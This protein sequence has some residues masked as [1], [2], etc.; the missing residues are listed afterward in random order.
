MEF[1]KKLQ[2]RHVER[3]EEMEDY[4]E[5]MREEE[6]EDQVE[7]VVSKTEDLRDIMTTSWNDLEK[8][9]RLPVPTIFTTAGVMTNHF[10]KML[11][12]KEREDVKSVLKARSRW[13]MLDG[14]LVDSNP[15]YH[16]RG[17]WIMTDSQAFELYA[18]QIF[19]KNGDAGV[20][21]LLC[22][23]NG[24]YVASVVV[25]GS[26][27]LKEG[28]Y[29][30]VING[31]TIIMSDIMF[32]MTTRYEVNGWFTWD[33]VTS[34]YSIEAGPV[35]RNHVERATIVPAFYGMFA[36]EP[37]TKRAVLAVVLEGLEVARFTGPITEIVPKMRYLGGYCSVFSHDPQRD[38]A[39]IFRHEMKS[40][41]ESATPQVHIE[42]AGFFELG[43]T[44]SKFTL[45]DRKSVV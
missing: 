2:H 34:K 15:T 11:L 1:L 12:T 4:E 43:V 24:V 42:G 14:R 37:K 45:R 27:P 13:T 6:P 25:R 29:D 32:H 21:Q 22:Y 35:L 9:M 41:D 33:I 36:S 3:T 5:I 23:V 39:T 31:R 16:V 26:V 44:W 40:T 8:A 30:V 10:G 28:W 20:H 38:I 19:L 17:E 18:E 7:I